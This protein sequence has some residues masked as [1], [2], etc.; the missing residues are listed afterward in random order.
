MVFRPG[1]LIALL[2]SLY[3]PST[4]VDMDPL[5][6]LSL[7]THGLQ[8]AHVQIRLANGQDLTTPEVQPANRLTYAFVGLSGLRRKQGKVLYGLSYWLSDEQHH[9]VLSRLDVRPD[10]KPQTEPAAVAFTLP[11]GLSHLQAGHRYRLR[12]RLFDKQGDGSLELQQYLEVKSQ[13]AHAAPAA[14]RQT[15]DN[16][17]MRL[18]EAGLHLHSLSLRDQATGQV[19][20]SPRIHFDQSLQLHLEGVTGFELLQGRG[21]PGAEFT[22]LSAQGEEIMH[23][24]DVMQAFATGAD[25]DTLAHHL[26]FYLRIPRYS[27]RPGRYL[28]SVRLYDRRSHRQLGGRVWLELE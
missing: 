24:A 22:V 21:L 12:L 19:L 8:L 11:V 7:A 26:A 28:W 14:E 1:F 15:R 13:V 5:L 3:V 16:G 9:P 4:T 6:S 27:L 18:D 17:P 25:A 10:L 20:A 23:Q 2:L